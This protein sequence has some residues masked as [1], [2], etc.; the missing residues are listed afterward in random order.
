MVLSEG[1]FIL[2]GVNDIGHAI[3]EVVVKSEIGVVVG[4]NLIHTLPMADLIRLGV[5]MGEN[6]WGRARGDM[7]VG[8]KCPSLLDHPCSGVV[9]SGSG[10]DWV[11]SNRSP[12]V[13]CYNI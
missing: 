3:A 13:T 1:Y 8:I 5:G 10:G 11:V 7:I 6:Q 9:Y 2:H 4:G 12:G